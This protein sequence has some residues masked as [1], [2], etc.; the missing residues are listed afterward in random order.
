MDSIAPP[1]PVISPDPTASAPVHRPNR[2]LVAL[3][4]SYNRLGHLQETLGALLTCAPDVLAAVLVVDN[5]SQDGS[6]DWL[7]AQQDPR[8]HV[9]RCDTNLGGA[10]GFELGL[11]HAMAE[12]S[13]DWVVVMDDDAR[14]APGALDAF[15]RLDLRGWDAVAGAA[16]HPDGR[17]C[18]MNRPTFNPFRHRWILLRSVLG[19]GRDAF[20][21]KA[22]DYAAP[23]LRPVDGASF[24]GLF[25][26]VRVFERAGFP[27]GRLFIYGDDAIFTMRLSRAGYRI[28]FCPAL[29][30]EHDSS[31]YGAEDPRI[32][33]LWK[34]YYYRRNLLILY[35]L[36]SGALFLPVAALF[37]LRWI[38]QIRHYPGERRGYLRLLRHAVGDGLRQRTDRPHER[39]LDLAGADDAGR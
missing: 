2:R 1:G 16:Y 39:V 20:H 38:M 22:E 34:I 11:R 6:G 29:R 25:L 7:R 32:R 31:T 5:A 17:I 9:I 4:V 24:V 23:G 36:A 26:H 10:G 8:L 15:H 21:L 13:P 28:A 27:E 14:P 35:R 33:P 18:E 37:I 19:G 3:V 30:F 12:L